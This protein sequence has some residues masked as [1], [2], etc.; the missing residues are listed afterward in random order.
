MAEPTP[1][2]RVEGVCKSFG[3]TAVL[4]GVDLVVPQGAIVAVLG[5]SGGGKTTLLRIV[6]GFEEPDAGTVT[7]D[8]T[9]VAGRGVST[10]A[11]RRRVGV[12]PQEG[13]LFPHL[14]VAGNVG[15]GLPRGTGRAA[16][17][18]EVLALV[19]LPG[20][21]RLRPHQLSGGQQ[22]R[23]AL[24]RAIAP[25]PSLVLLDE[26]F[27]ALDAGLRAQVRDEV[28]D[29]LQTSRTTA[30]IVT[31]DQQEALS[32]ADQVAVLLGGRM[33]QFAEPAVLYDEP[34]SL[35]VAT[36]VGE[37]VVLPGTATEGRVRCALGDLVLRT[38][39][40]GSVTV[41]VR[42]EQ[43]ELC[44]DHQGVAGTV[45][46]RSFFGHDGV[47]RVAIDGD[48]P[49]TVTARVHAARLPARR[50]GVRVRV[51]TPVSAYPPR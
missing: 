16:R 5:P 25:R 12:V 31:H 3:A 27:A 11:E 9:L 15:F 28:L 41:V 6:A 22:H 26:P 42:P 24:A 7:I 33:A 18:D 21:Q 19:G 32:V 4:D 35:A 29:A 49:T 10:A 2:L 17:I 20:A 37:A 34:A 23:V 43:I 46:S 36:F 48:A 39:A 1:A 38:P 14:D 30:V 40:T 51:V 50:A 47:V 8:G 13:A 44:G 45:V